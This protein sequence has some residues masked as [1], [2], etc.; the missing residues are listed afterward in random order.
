ME[1]QPASL[2][3]QTTISATPANPVS[4]V[5]STRRSFSWS[6]TVPAPANLFITRSW[7]LPPNNGDSLIPVTQKMIESDPSQTE[8]TPRMIIIPCL[9][10][11][12]PENYAAASY[13]AT[14]NIVATSKFQEERWG[15]SCQ[16]CA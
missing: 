10:S 1:Q 4:N 9:V 13:P 5:H 6:N 7:P 16:C 14:T 15:S 3:P 2:I 8:N 12:I 11:L